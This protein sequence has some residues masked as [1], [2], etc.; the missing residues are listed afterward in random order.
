MRGE[1]GVG[2][3]G[4]IIEKVKETRMQG[5]LEETKEEGTPFSLFRRRRSP[6][7]SDVNRSFLRSV[8]RLRSVLLSY[9]SFSVR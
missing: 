7:T 1:C 2:G 3:A 5:E 9:I 8:A 6:V 4:F